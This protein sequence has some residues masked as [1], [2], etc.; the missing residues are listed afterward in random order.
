MEEQTRESKTDM[1]PVWSGVRGREGKG[2]NYSETGGESSVGLTTSTD[3]NSSCQL[4]NKPF[5][6]V[7]SPDLVPV[8]TLGAKFLLLNCINAVHQMKD[9][10]LRNLFPILNILFYAHSC[11]YPHLSEV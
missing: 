2:G 10:Y 5:S 6:T 3:R 11:F 1:T 8:E 9:N 4:G 7:H